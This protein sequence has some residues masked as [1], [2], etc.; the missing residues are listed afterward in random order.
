M[1]C[2][3]SYRISRNF[4]LWIQPNLSL[5]IWLEAPPTIFWWRF[6]CVYPRVE[7]DLNSNWWHSG[8]NH[9]MHNWNWGERNKK[10]N[11][12]EFS[13]IWISYFGFYWWSFKGFALLLIN[14]QEYLK[15]FDISN[16][17]MSSWDIWDNDKKRA[18]TMKTT[19]LYFSTIVFWT[20]RFHPSRSSP[21]SI[22]FFWLDNFRICIWHVTCDISFMNYV[23]VLQLVKIK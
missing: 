16:K 1:R 9:H 2:S 19:I 5:L 13:E 3:Y 21:N 22:Y 15:Y 7:I 18:R 11:D 8:S 10:L 20:N 17:S 6:D 23:N 4:W 14:L 12:F